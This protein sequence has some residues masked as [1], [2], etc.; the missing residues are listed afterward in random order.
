VALYLWPSRKSYT[1]E[2]L[3][4]VHA[5][6]SP[7]LL[8]A[9]LGD[10]FGSGAR[11]A[12]PG[13][14]TLR[15]FLSG[16]LDLV[17]AEAVLGVIDA[18]GES[19]LRVALEQLAGGLSG[20]IGAVRGDLLD[21]LADLEAGLDFTE[22]GI[23]FVSRGAL[24][25]RMES[26]RHALQAVL[27]Q[28]VGRIQ[29]ATRLR[30]VL[31][32]LPNAGKSTLFNAL[33]G[34]PLALVSDVRGTT[35]DYLR[36]ELDWQGLSLELIDTAGWDAAADPLLR[37]ALRLRDD[38]LRRADLIVWC[39]AADALPSPAGHATPIPLPDFEAS[40]SRPVLQVMTKSDLS[41]ATGLGQLCLSAHSGMGLAEFQAAVV[42]ELTRGAAG[43]GQLLG[44]TTARC[45]ESLLGALA[46]LERG[47]DVAAGSG[48]EEFLAVDV[49]D[50]LAELGKITGA[51]YTDDILDR[52]FSKFCIGK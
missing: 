4:E 31:A 22:E 21:L 44:M 51:V 32:G 14:F 16:R 27:D 2:P 23:E 18:Q 28:A 36:A 46:A 11:P 33:A 8:E 38:Q 47:L 48:G 29:S 34:K 15:A 39:T 40:G 1:G 45:R 20:K 19:E 30:V 37:E 6:G 25:K 50:A 41:N 42:A 17:Q 7:P 9:M 49:R 26:A 43:D 10:L 3:A 35:R 12:R 52:I 24:V 5:V 13:E